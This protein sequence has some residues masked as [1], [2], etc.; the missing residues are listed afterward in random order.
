MGIYPTNGTEGA[1]GEARD[2]MSEKPRLI[3]RIKGCKIKRDEKCFLDLIGHCE[4][5]PSQN[6]GDLFNLF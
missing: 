2:M 6:M 3:G 5:L 1:D 4:V